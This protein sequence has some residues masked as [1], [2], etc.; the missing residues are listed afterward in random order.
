MPAKNT[1]FNFAVLS[2]GRGALQEPNFCPDEA[3]EPCHKTHWLNLFHPFQRTE[4]FTQ[5][6]WKPK[7]LETTPSQ[8]SPHPVKVSRSFRI[9][10]R[11]SIYS[12]YPKKQTLVHMLYQV[13]S[14]LCIFAE[15]SCRAG[16]LTMPTT[17][18][19]LPLTENWSWSWPSNN[20]R[21]QNEQ[22]ARQCPSHD[23]RQDGASFLFGF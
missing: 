13:K 19:A 23:R 8:L 2:Y 1:H 11:C 17:S 14:G 4:E 5:V 22:R 7:G 10:H 3:P 20:C 6:P 21:N 18:W 16:C 12:F 9:Q 15:G